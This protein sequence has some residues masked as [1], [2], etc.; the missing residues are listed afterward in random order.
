MNIIGTFAIISLFAAIIGLVM[1]FSASDD[2]KKIETEH[3]YYQAM[4]ANDVATRQATVTD[5]IKNDKG[6]KWWFEYEI[7][8]EG[9]D[10]TVRSYLE[11]WSLPIYNYNQLPA[12]DSTITV[13]LSNATVNSNTNSIPA[14]P[15]D[16]ELTKPENDG[17]Y[18]DAKNLNN[19]GTMLMWICGGLFV[20]LIVAEVAV[21]ARL[22]QNRDTNT[23]NTG[24][25]G[26]TV[27]SSGAPQETYSNCPYCSA[28]VSSGDK[29]CSNC[30]A[31]VK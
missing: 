29:K 11:G 21:F 26:G 1:M 9:S 5:H 27:S 25:A 16:I 14:R 3:I 12:I 15:I 28:K 24:N 7:I 19:I 20:A 8:F 10:E 13:V 30:G 17:D 4:L 2:M 18:I 6:D 23:A 31:H 22:R